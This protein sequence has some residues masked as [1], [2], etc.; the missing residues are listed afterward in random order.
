MAQPEVVVKACAYGIVFLYDEHAWHC[1]RFI[2]G[3]NHTSTLLFFRGPAMLCHVYLF[4]FF[5]HDFSFYSFF[6]RLLAR[7][8]YTS[9]ARV[10]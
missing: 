8:I 4:R 3:S 1:R 5:C 7:I 9:R 6:I 10:S 2:L